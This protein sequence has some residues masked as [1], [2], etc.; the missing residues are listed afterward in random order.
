MSCNLLLF[1]VRGNKRKHVSPD[2]F[3]VLGVPKRPR[4]NYILW[5]EKKRPAIVIECTSSSTKREDQKLK[6]ELYRD[7]LKV[8]EYLMFDPRADYLKPRFQGY[9]RV[10]TENRPIPI[11]GGRLL[12][13]QLNLLFESDG[14]HLRIVNPVTNERLPTP[15][16][17][18]AQAEGRALREAAKREQA[19][20]ERLRRE[21]EE[22][23]RLA[24][25]PKG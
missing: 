11:V 13:K 23:R 14:E 25:E 15:A 6:F 8:P 3:V 9:R 24:A 4:E 10:A 19:E 12:S 18:K 21:N 20:V 1:Y 22:L 2:T 7:V 16:E 17:A 5:D